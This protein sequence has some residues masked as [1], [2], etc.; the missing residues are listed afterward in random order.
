MS[1]LFQRRGLSLDRLRSFLAVADAGAIARAAP[2]NPI[3]QSQLSRQ[4]AELEAFFGKALVERRGRG[5]ALTD[6][7]VRLAV[8][9]RETLQ[10]LTDVAASGSERAI[11]ASLGAGDHLLHGWL[12]PRLPQLHG[13][14][15]LALAAMDPREAIARL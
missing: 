6:A 4:I 15:A 2:G 10:G 9:V 8:V 11:A 1:D 14:V 5:L 13:R 3:K 7:G 12:I